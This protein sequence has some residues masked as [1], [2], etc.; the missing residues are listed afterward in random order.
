MAKG[1]HIRVRKGLYWHHGIDLGDGRV[2]HYSGL[3]NGLNSGPVT[4]VPFPQFS[5]LK[6]VECVGHRD[7]RHDPDQ[8]V[9]R[10]LF[11]VGED[12]YS[13]LFNNCEH[14]CHW[15]IEGRPVSR[16]VFQRGAELVIGFGV[17]VVGWA[18]V[19]G[20]GR[21]K[22]HNEPRAAVKRSAATTSL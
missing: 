5:G 7:P 21:A 22:D 8:A 4:L 17:L 18:L 2:A 15:V 3:V 13:V 16:Q 1:D 14:F 20:D 19:G 12:N 6:Q 11:R 10:A 9:Q